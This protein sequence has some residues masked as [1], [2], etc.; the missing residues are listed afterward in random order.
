M[1]ALR[2]LPVVL[3]LLLVS[4]ACA[5]GPGPSASPGGSAGSSSSAHPP[6]GIPAFP[7]VADAEPTPV[8][9]TPGT[10]LARDVRAQQLDVALD[11]RHAYA[12]LVWWSGVE[13]CNV[14]D[15]VTLQQTGSELFLTIREGTTDP[16]AFC[17]ELAMLKST[18]VDLGELEPGTYTISAFGDAAPL[19]IEVA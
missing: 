5:A 19:T 14:L 17:I 1:K 6:A 13:P 11:G 8:V 3:P 7:P 12:R 10:Q 15:S 18:I 4:A 9:A 16:D 2:L